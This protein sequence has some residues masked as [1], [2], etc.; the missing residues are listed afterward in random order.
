M[1]DICQYGDGDHADEYGGDHPPDG[2]RS[3]RLLL[4]H[5]T[6]KVPQVPE[7]DILDI[8]LSF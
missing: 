3:L 6:P 2:Q 4:I 1:R 5:L 8:C 7:K